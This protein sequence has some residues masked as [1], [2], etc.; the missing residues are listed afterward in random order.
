MFVAVSVLA[1]LASSFRTGRMYW[2]ASGVLLATA[3]FVSLLNYVKVRVVGWAVTVPLFY[4]DVL[5]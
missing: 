3:V 1:L 5:S 4:L 2:A